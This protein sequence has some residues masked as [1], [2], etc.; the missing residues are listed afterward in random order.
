MSKTSRKVPAANKS[1]GK[2]MSWPAGVVKLPKV[3]V[4]KK[5]PRGG[6]V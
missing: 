2:R 4:Q 1:G 6:Y 5:P 3:R